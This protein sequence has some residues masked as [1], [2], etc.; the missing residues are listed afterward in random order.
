MQLSDSTATYSIQEVAQLCGLPASTLRYYESIGLLAPVHRDQS[1]RHRVY[2][3]IDL[4]I[5]TAVACLSAA[6]LSVAD[7]RQ[8]LTNREH[9]ADAAADQ[10]VLLRAHQRRLREALRDLRLRQRYIDRKVEFWEAVADGDDERRAAISVEV[11]QIAAQLHQ[12][13][14]ARG[15]SA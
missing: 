6:G 9:G 10:I 2:D 8:Y 14:P 11:N 3:D 4:N 15:G 7:M 12:G 5:A 1:S 13:K